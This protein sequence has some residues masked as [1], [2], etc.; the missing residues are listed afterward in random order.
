MRVALSITPAS[1]KAKAKGCICHSETEIDI[2]CPIHFTL[3]YL[4][5]MKELEKYIR[6]TMRQE[7]I[8]LLSLIVLLILNLISQFFG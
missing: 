3:Y 7:R 5:L 1:E 8:W 4:D 6:K 2:E